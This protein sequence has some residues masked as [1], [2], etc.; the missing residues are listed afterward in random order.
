MFK[1]DIFFQNTYLWITRKLI[2][3]LN[4]FYTDQRI[5]GKQEI[6]P[7]PFCLFLFLVAQY[8]YL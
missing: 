3:D 8:S 6:Y 7:V 5:L 4:C 2:I 1:T